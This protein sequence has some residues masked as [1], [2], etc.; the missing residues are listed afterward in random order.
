MEGFGC[1]NLAIVV[2]PACLGMCLAPESEQDINTG[3]KHARQHSG[4][5]YAHCT[6]HCAGDTRPDCGAPWGIV[7]TTR[8]DRVIHSEVLSVKVS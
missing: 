1:N 3:P 6:E 4:T 8:Q 7:V 2:L 5:I